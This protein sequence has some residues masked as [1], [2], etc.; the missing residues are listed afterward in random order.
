VGATRD[1]NPL[2]LRRC[3]DS[4]HYTKMQGLLPLHYW[5][6]P[7]ITRY[8]G[9]EPCSKTW[10]EN[11]RRGYQVTRYWKV[12]RN[13]VGGEVGDYG[14]VRW[15]VVALKF[16]CEGGVIFGVSPARRRGIVTIFAVFENKVIVYKESRECEY[17]V[18]Q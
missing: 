16:E 7:R 15:M 18:I 5:G 10:E 11:K 17:S 8:F 2:A 13:L 1:S 14:V 6:R 12:G 9:L 3:R 4:Y